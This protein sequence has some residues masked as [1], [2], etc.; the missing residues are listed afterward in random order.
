MT[1]A[2]G[3]GHPTHAYVEDRSP[4]HGRL[5]PRAVAPS[6]APS[7]DL[8]GDWSFRLS[9]GLA[10]LADGFEK[11]DYGASGWDAIPVPSCW[12][13]VGLPE[14]RYGAPA[15]TNV[16]Y[17]FPVDPPRVPD[18]N[19]TGEY[20]REFGLPEAWPAGRTVLRFEGVDSCFAVWLNG[21]HLGDGKGSRLP[22][23][24]DVTDALQGG[25]NV[26]AVRVHQWS[27]GSYL[28][29]QDMWWLSGIFRSVRL[30]A[31]PAGALGDHFVHADYDHH[32]G[33]GTLRVDTDVPA[34]LTIPALGLHDVDA[35]GPHTIA[36][37]T[38]WSAEHPHLYDAVLATAGERARLRI[39]FRTVAIVDG[40][41]AVNGRPILFRGVN[42]HE[43][44]PETGRTLSA[45]TMRA[46]V[47]LMKQHNINAVR[48]SHYPPDPA[49][50]DLCDAYGLWVIDECDLE[51]HG[52][53]QVG[54]RGNPSDD[55]R[56]QPA[57]LDRMARM[58]ER[59]KN[60]PSVIGWSLGNESGTG[61]NLAAMAEW[62]RER[63]S[64]RFVHYEGDWDSGYVD[65]YSRMYAG[66]AEVDQVGR[67][68]EQPTQDPSLDARRRN[69]PFI[70]CEYAHAMGNGPGGLREYQ[71]LFE[72]HA[73]CQGGFVWE[74]ID[75]GVTVRTPDGEPYFAY[76]GDF[77]EPLHDGNFIADGL[78][79][80]DRTPSPGLIEYAKVIEP[81][82]ITIDQAI[83][84]R[85]GYDVTDTGGLTFV[86]MLEHDGI[87]EATGELDVPTLPPGGQVT[88]GLPI[89]AAQSR[90]V[91]SGE[92][93]LTVRA[94]LT[95]GASWAPAGHCV[96]WGQGQLE[97]PVQPHLDQA[98][99]ALSE[100]GQLGLDQ[101]EPGL[102]AETAA[103]GFRL[104]PA[105][106]DPRGR[107]VRLGDLELIGPTL[108]LWRAPTDNDEPPRRVEKVAEA[109][110]Q[111]G[112]HRLRHKVTEVQPSPDGLTVVTHVM[113]AGTDAGMRAQFT[114]RARPDGAN[115]RAALQLALDVTPLG[116]WTTPIPRLGLRLGVP[117]SISAVEWFGRGPGEAYA[118]TRQA[119]RVGRFAA[120]VDELQTHYV[121]PQEN[122]SRAD[123]RWARL[124]DG[125][126]AGM[127]VRGEPTFDLTVRRWTSEHLDAAQHSCDL[128]ADET[129]WVNLDVGQHGIGS[130]SCGP[131]VLPQHRLAAATAQL[132]LTLN[133]VVSAEL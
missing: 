116:E 27:S 92:A 32:T 103:D 37:V 114:W 101:P 28:E 98:R 67:R 102:P 15:Y 46:D 124:T 26:L 55:E 13:L 10:E 93:W 18:E 65:V 70:Q 35:A 123:V 131:G 16:T 31:R 47:L 6:D 49:F 78:L 106:F 107:L 9:G 8:A 12:Q 20:R 112:L 95:D 132:T 87:P 88:V 113:P 50:L 21:T 3:A 34:R 5:A 109:W 121:R 108:D 75:H 51:T 133:R 82:R 71:D 30:L 115:G 45:E 25:R 57:L 14:R 81:V 119:A 129:V 60:H 66:H 54:W 99:S 39:G 59:D 74:W 85:N 58:V 83:T 117:A 77:G 130:A 17:P 125:A 38:P 63:D 24:F 19:P 76:G 110:R 23:E 41:L 56:W 90:P 48:T 11:V 111:L 7:L 69:L 29:D 122:G 62:V 89:T 44:H 64:S 61:R 52:F 84:I 96:A 73:R 126:G 120:T 79:F 1:Q 4:G 68:T 40:Q 100:E 118:D 53:Q 2:T 127:L 22:T 104:G 72:A 33:G 43:W 91:D 128:R 97:R 94:V 42:R 80:P 36:A 105:R 86:W